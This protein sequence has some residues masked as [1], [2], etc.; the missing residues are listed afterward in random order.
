MQRLS[1]RR[2]LIT[3]AASGVGRNIAELFAAEGALVALLDRNAK[4]VQAV[5]TAIG[6]QAFGFGCDVSA[7]A[8]VAITVAN[9]AKAMGGIDG[10]VNA[11]GVLDIKPFA[12]LDPQSWDR[13][14]AI[15]LTGPFNIIHAALPMLQAA[16]TA[17][18][19]NIAS[20]SALMPMAGTSGYSASKAGLV[21][22]TKCLGFDLGPKIRANTICPGTIRTEMTRYLWENPEHLA[23]ASER[24]ALNRLGNTEDVAN[25][26]L[27]LSSQ[28]SAFT[29]GCELTVDGGFSWR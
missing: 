17:T 11:A 5:A 18:I 21:M 20:V 27:F 1:G 4:G 24:A 10:I 8:E 2:I 19:V 15:N 29:T 25:A 13:M 12:E 3:G 26:A 9:A 23:R 7:R 14:L 22:F 16:E 6:N 28:E